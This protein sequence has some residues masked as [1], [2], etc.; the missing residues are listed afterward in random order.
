MVDNSGDGDCNSEYDMDLQMEQ[1]EDLDTALAAFEAGN[2]EAFAK[3]QQ[4][5]LR[6]QIL[7]SVGDKDV[8]IG[9]LNKLVDF[10]GTYI[11]SLEGRFNSLQN[12]FFDSLFTG[13][14]DKL[15]DTRI[16]ELFD[17]FRGTSFHKFFVEDG[18][19][20]EARVETHMA[21][22]E[23]NQVK[24]EMRTNTLRT[25]EADTRTKLTRMK[26]EYD[27]VS[28]RLENKKIELQNVQ[29]QFQAGS[30]QTNHFY[31]QNPG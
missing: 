24:V 21:S 7:A 28:I 29:N 20:E 30:S 4:S 2:S 12:M 23:V 8:L 14:K 13:L 10:Q 11:Y 22:H 3:R 16:R 9:L 17:F 19:T 27:N 6:A 5:D 26:T 1:E 18:Y 15:D 25:A 31:I